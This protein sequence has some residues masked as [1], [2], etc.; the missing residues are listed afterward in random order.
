[1]N[2]DIYFQ[3]KPEDGIKIYLKDS[4]EELNKLKLYNIT[5]NENNIYKDIQDLED[6][7]LYDVEVNNIRM[8]LK[9]HLTNIGFY[10][11]RFAVVAK[12][13][14]I[15]QLSN[16]YTIPNSGYYCIY[17]NPEVYNAISQLDYKSFSIQLVSN[18]WKLSDFNL[19]NLVARSGYELIFFID[20][21]K[22]EDRVVLNELRQ[23][24]L[25]KRCEALFDICTNSE[26]N[27]YGKN[28][29]INTSAQD[30]EFLDVS[31]NHNLPYFINRGNKI[32]VKSPNDL[33]RIKEL[34]LDN[35]NKHIK[36][37][38]AFQKEISQI[39]EDK[40]IRLNDLLLCLADYM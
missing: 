35:Y 38:E 1:M 23:E 27:Y 13:K 31:I 22:E 34:M 36:S 33:L 21:D 39:F 18:D 14:Y 30:L 20:S 9:D 7:S 15:S 25:Q 11:L 40:T 2:K 12:N 32:D 19:D 6:P 37:I 26:L 28:I 3:I 17:V 8:N 29:V 5:T 10:D 24:A 4:N 16:V